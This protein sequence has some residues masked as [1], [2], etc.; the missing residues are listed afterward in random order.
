MTEI[1]SMIGP[2]YLKADRIS[3][4]WP[5]LEGLQERMGERADTQED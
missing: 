2:R 1:T 5:K 3:G 4:P